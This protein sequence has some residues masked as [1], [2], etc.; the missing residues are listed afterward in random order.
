MN[1][2]FI[3]RLLW[4]LKIEYPR[5]Q[6]THSYR[7]TRLSSSCALSCLHSLLH[8]R[9]TKSF[10]F[11]SNPLI[12]SGQ[13]KLPRFSSYSPFFRHKER[14]LRNLK[15]REIADSMCSASSSLRISFFFVIKSSFLRPEERKGLKAICYTK[16]NLL[17]IPD[18]KT[19]RK[20]KKKKSLKSQQRISSCGIQLAFCENLG[21]LFR[22][23]KGGKKAVGAICADSIVSC[24]ASSSIIQICVSNIRE[25]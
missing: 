10:Q 25:M 6:Q 1:S 22:R 15:T 21:D 23:L 19:H 20:A 8:K 16:Q 2:K 17:E 5:R 13:Q 4:F 7:I 12:T 11:L 14:N 3:G 24:S 18:E 9:L